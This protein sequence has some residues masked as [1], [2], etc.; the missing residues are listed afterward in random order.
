MLLKFKKLND[1]AIV[2][3]YGTESA[4]GAD[5]YALPEGDT[6]IR[7]G[8]TALIHTGIC[9][10]IPEGYVGLIYAR[11]G[12]ATK[13]GLA[14]ANKVGVIDSDYRGEIMVSLYNHS[15]AEQTVASGERV[16]QIV[17]APYVKADFCECDTLDETER[18]S[19]GFGST[20]TK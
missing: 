1:N 11:S 7:P 14:P 13:R 5:L 9:M 16:A 17:I 19:G 20:G 8:Q 18:S 10:Q 6:V 3:T 2:P 4:A 12:I 15:N